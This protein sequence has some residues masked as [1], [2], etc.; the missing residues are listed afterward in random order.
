MRQAVWVA[1]STNH[2]EGLRCD[3]YCSPCGSK[4]ESCRHGMV[5]KSHASCEGMEPMQW[6]ACKKCWHSS[7][8][9]MCFT[10]MPALQQWDK[11]K[12]GK[13][14]FLAWEWWR[15]TRWKEIR[16][17]TTHAWQLAPKSLSCRNP[18][19]CTGTWAVW[20][21]TRTDSPTVQ[22][23]RCVRRWRSGHWFYV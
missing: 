1:G 11:L 23:S 16:L 4:L 10:S 12:T 21:F 6:Q 3:A 18:L 13:R 15:S 9:Q 20:R 7:C 17:P 8:K 19:P 5:P 22:P 2:P 14:P